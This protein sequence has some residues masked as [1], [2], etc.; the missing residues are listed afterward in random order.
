MRA[1][2]FICIAGVLLVAACKPPEKVTPPPAYATPAQVA[3][4][5]AAVFIGAGDIGVCGLQG[6][7]E[8][9]QLVDSVLKADS[10]AGVQSMAFTTGEA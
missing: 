3:L 1:A 8:T 6:D 2:A 4:S 10:A 5:G 9:A 7:E